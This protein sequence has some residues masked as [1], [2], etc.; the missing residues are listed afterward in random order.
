MCSGNTYK[1]EL[2]AVKSDDLPEADR[3]G[4]AADTATHDASTFT[5]NR[6]RQARS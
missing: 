5:I 6:R 1:P 2:E 3:P 4:K